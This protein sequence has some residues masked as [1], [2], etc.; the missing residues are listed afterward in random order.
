M[1]TVL[2]THKIFLC[3]SILFCMGNVYL[4]AQPEFKLLSSDQTGIHFKNEVPVYEKMNVLI[5]QYHYN[6]GGVAIG[7][8]NNDDLQD[9]FFIKN[10]GDD[11]LYLNKGDF[12]FEEVGKQAGV[13]G[14]ISWETGVTL[15]D[16][17]NDG[18]TDIYVSRSGLAPNTS[19]SNLLYINQG[20]TEGEK[21]PI[22]KEQAINFG[23]F[24][25]SHSTDASFFDY[26][27]DGDLDM[28]MLNH[29][30]RRIG[31][32]NFDK[33]EVFHNEE[34]GDKLFRNDNGKFEEV[35]TEAG[36]IGKEISNGLGVMIGD[37]DQD[38]WPDIYVCN[39]FGE[40][41]YFYINNGD[42]TFREKLKSTFD[43]IPYYSMGGDMADFNNDGWLD[44]MTLDM[45][46][47]DNYGQKANMNDM[48]PD[49]FWFL[50]DK[51][52]HYQY[53]INCM[54]LNNGVVGGK[55]SFSNIAYFAGAAY[56]D[57]SW[58]PLFADFDNDGKKDL[59][60]TNGYRVNISNK[61]YVQWYKKREYE[62]AQLPY[63]QRNNA[64]ELQEAL[65][66]LSS[67]KTPNYMFKNAGDL[68]F[69]N[70]SENWGFSDSSFSNGVAYGDFDNDGDLDLV[71]NNLDQEAFIYQNSQQG[72]NYLTIQLIGSPKNRWG[73][74]T[75]V[76]V[77]TGDDIQ[78]QEF[79]VNRG[80]QSSTMPMLH[81]GLG[82]HQKIDLMEVEW[83]DGRRQ[84][85]RN[86]SV[87]RK[88][89]LKWEEAKE[90][91]ETN[92]QPA[93]H[94]FS[95][96]T[97]KSGVD[98]VHQEN[99]FDDF[100]REVL[101]PHKLS[102]LGPALAVGDINSDGLDDFFVGGAKGL[103]GQLFIQTSS[104]TFTAY[105]NPILESHKQYEDIDAHFFDS[106]QDGD[107]DL[108]VV[109][110]GNENEEK[111]ALLQDRLYL[112]DGNGQFAVS[113]KLPEMYSSGSC[114]RTMDF[115]GDGDEDIFVGGRLVPG[116]Y[117]YPGVSYLLRNEG[118]KFIDIT[119][120]I[121]PDLREIG[122]V[123]DA[124]WSDYD[125]DG[126]PD[127][128]LVGE[129]MPI[130][131]FQNQ[132]GKSFTHSNIQSFTKSHGW[133]NNLNQADFD[134]DG[135]IDYIAGNLGLNYKYKASQEY[136]FEIYTKDFD[137][138]GSFDI[139]L[140]YYEGEQLFP[141]RGRQC[142]AEQI[143][144]IKQKYETYNSFAAASLE[145]VYAGMGLQEALNYKAY[146][147]SSV[148]IENLGE[149][150]FR[151][152][153]LP[154]YAQIA[155]IN[156]TIIKDIDQDGFIDILLA[157]NQYGSEVETP[158]ADAGKGL[159]LKGNGT[160]SF[161]A[162]PPNQSGFLASGDVKNMRSIKLG[163]NRRGIIVSP[164]QGGLRI[165]GIS[166]E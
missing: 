71:I 49:K 53:M 7:D 99:P 145:E 12:K 166:Q 107:L 158:R 131:I 23:L 127:L 101:L 63:T 10:F 70:V 13:S 113:A 96:M 108:Y 150:K 59:F 157:G 41:D 94:L 112:N 74:G 45:T 122:M 38:G 118:E 90:T 156:T 65:S 48:N 151:F 24:D 16:I 25:I 154:N 69:Q 120:E 2:Y 135:D 163:N 20:T 61:D 155:P 51:G 141:L 147:F 4:T 95:D 105:K 121:A 146:T 161:N 58:A 28:F 30:I 162:I 40:R 117:P 76:W 8:F 119:S 123:T 100:E 26:D 46:A 129:W 153:Q 109:S 110:G 115:D 31:N 106:D 132:N 149:D 92:T 14:H 54:Q 72:N 33:P 15:V 152:H 164:N 103:S 125:Q 148:M 142:S 52:M 160:F 3:F 126:D 85:I 19:Y 79:Y 138:N 128:F 84:E 89:S 133:W 80:Y 22:F 134:G 62:L 139:V 88:L 68:E 87:N 73:I 165:W 9:I 91:K 81:F 44:I 47:S 114:V 75:K 57:W 11:E 1:C 50:V 116:K 104:A 144:T 143:P 83:P 39:D 6:G 29:N 35:S 55:L 27:K 93:A 130:T 32:Y 86:L 140:G 77:Y 98:Y 17:N 34:V 159:L 56:T 66:R 42:G 102:T 137:E 21:I 82:K 124:L 67:D 136:P 64:Q 43:Q 97:Q 5:S 36:L 18:W 60:I 78:Y 111:S 37:V